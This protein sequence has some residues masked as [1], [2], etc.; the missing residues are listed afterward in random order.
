MEGVQ[1]AKP[2]FFVKLPHSMSKF[3]RL[4]QQNDSKEF[5]EAIKR[6]LRETVRSEMLVY[7]CFSP[8]CAAHVGYTNPSKPPFCSI[9][10]HGSF[11]SVPFVIRSSINDSGQ[12][13]VRN[14]CRTLRHV[15]INSMKIKAIGLAPRSLAANILPHL[16]AI[17]IS[18]DH[19]SPTQV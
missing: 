10:V 5:G 12:P 17:A 7:T 9:C 13:L 16:Q 15:M 18:L 8:R 2:C 3:R 6:V 19:A 4:L 14:T 1:C 11:N